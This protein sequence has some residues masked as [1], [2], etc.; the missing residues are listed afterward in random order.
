[1]RKN[2][3]FRAE[4]MG[5]EE[6]YKLF[7]STW[8]IPLRTSVLPKYW[9][10]VSFC[11]ADYFLNNHCHGAKNQSKHSTAQSSFVW[12]AFYELYSIKRLWSSGIWVCAGVDGNPFNPAGEEPDLVKQGQGQRKPQDNSL[13]TSQGASPGSRSPDFLHFCLHVIIVVNEKG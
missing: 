6:N 12:A 1:M 8:V 7:L 9:G 5:Y 11:L 4:D 10:S 2:L 3:T 13:E